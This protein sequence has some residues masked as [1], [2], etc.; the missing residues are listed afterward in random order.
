LKPGTS[1]LSTLRMTKSVVQVRAEV[2][3]GQN[4]VFAGTGSGG[5]AGAV[6][7]SVSAVAA[8]FGEGAQ[9]D[10]AMKEMAARAA[11]SFLCITITHSMSSRTRFG[12]PVNT[13][14]WNTVFFPR[15]F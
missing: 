5:A 7:A 11:E 6:L 8:V 2:Y 10:K 15:T 14:P 1:L 3:M 4:A 13:W 12:R 9:A